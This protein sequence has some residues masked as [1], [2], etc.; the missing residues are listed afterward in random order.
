MGSATLNFTY[1]FLER[2]KATTFAGHAYIN[3]RPFK[4]TQDSN[5]RHRVRR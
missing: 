5:T 3:L 2:D 1:R 4:I